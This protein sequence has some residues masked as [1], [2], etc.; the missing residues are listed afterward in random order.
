MSF[1]HLAAFGL[2]ILLHTLHD[3]STLVQVMAWC[4][5][6]TSYYLSQYWPRSV[7]PYNIS[8]PYWVNLSNQPPTHPYLLLQWESAG[9]LL[10]SEGVVTPC[11]LL[12]QLIDTLCQVTHLACNAQKYHI[13]LEHSCVHP[14]DLHHH[15]G[16]QWS[17]T[18]QAPSH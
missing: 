14:S 1:S 3:K 2:A 6:A 15:Q 13:T 7:S 8:R 17:G 4:C 9:G 11:Q 18:K 16:Y 10:C 5:E 12:T